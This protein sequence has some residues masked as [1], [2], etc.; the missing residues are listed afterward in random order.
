MNHFFSI[1]LAGLTLLLLEQERSI[2]ANR[3]DIDA[4]I[5]VLDDSQKGR[6]KASDTDQQKDAALEKDQRQ[7]TFNYINVLW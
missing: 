1:G 6:H 7:E 4:K 3:M 5:R 2:V